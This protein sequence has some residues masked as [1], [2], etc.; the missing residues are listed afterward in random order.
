MWRLVPPLISEMGQ[1]Y[2]ELG[3]AQ[4]LMTEILKLE[5]ARFQKT[6]ERGLKLLSEETG[7]LARD[8]ALPGA[9]AF[10]LYDTY[11]FPLD[12]TQDVLRGQ[13][14]DVDVDGFNAAMERQKEEARAAW[15][16]P[17]RRPRKKSGSRSASAWGPRNF[18]AMT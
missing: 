17:A 3:R 12:L 16:V 7:K 13:G 4:A 11:G 8:A 18:S 9:A 2:P 14:R 1:V 6:L 5:E 15:P 10:K